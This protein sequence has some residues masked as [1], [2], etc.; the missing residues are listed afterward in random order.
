MEELTVKVVQAGGKYGSFLC[1][2]CNHDANYKFTASCGWCD[3]CGSHFILTDG[4]DLT[5]ADQGQFGPHWLRL[6]REPPL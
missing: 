5:I 3:Q 6:E 4:L 2:I 1:P